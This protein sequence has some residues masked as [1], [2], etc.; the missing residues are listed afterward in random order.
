MAAGRIIQAGSQWLE[1][2]VDPDDFI[3]MYNVLHFV[4]TCAAVFYCRTSTW[5]MSF[6]FNTVHFGCQT[7]EQISHKIWK[8]GEQNAG[9]LL[10]PAF[11]RW[12]YHCHNLAI[13]QP[14][15]KLMEPPRWMPPLGNSF[16]VRGCWA[17]STQ[18]SDCAADATRTLLVWIA[19]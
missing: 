3:V 5:H 6:S 7:M 15:H 9:T 11:Y 8:Y 18:N 14:S 13:L 17:V 12:W 2:T 10:K 4:F 16:G 19:G 1:N